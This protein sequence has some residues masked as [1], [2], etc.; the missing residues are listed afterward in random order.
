MEESPTGNSRNTCGNRRN[1]KGNAREI[2][3]E[4]AGNGQKTGE[5]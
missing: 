4:M 5:T 2:P 1:T 3:W